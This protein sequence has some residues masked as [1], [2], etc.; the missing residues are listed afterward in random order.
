MPTLTGYV[1]MHATTVV[2]IFTLNDP[3]NYSNI[4][5]T[6]LLIAMTMACCFPDFVVSFRYNTQ[7][8]K[9]MSSNP[10]G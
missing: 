8:R 6:I 10:P 9:C 5:M 1:H 7:S 3:A 4:T 2:T